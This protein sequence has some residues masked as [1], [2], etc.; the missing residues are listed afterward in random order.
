MTVTGSCSRKVQAQSW[1][2][3]PPPCGQVSRLSYIL[4]YLLSS[5]ASLCLFVSVSLCLYLSLLPV[6]PYL[7]LSLCFRLFFSLCLCLSVS[8]SLPLPLCLPLSLCHC[9]SISL[10]LS[11]CLSVS[12]SLF[13]PLFLC[14]CL[15]ASLP[16]SLCLS[17]R[18][19]L[20][21]SPSITLSLPLSLCLSLSLPPSGPPLALASPSVE[22]FSVGEGTKKVGEEAQPSQPALDFH[23]ASPWPQIKR[24]CIGFYF[25]GFISRIYWPS[26]LSLDEAARS[27]IQS[28]SRSAGHPSG[29]SRSGTNL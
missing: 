1:P 16:V 25:C 19:S 2:P 13:L 28:S 29:T 24:L 8:V 23:P 5:S 26:V 17:L 12:V 14:L 22:G 21:V 7:S 11:P 18:P 9:L 3:R 6:S 27:Y 20:S 10:C 4:I 15:S